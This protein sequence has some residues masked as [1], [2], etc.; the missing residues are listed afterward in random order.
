MVEILDV[1][2][3]LHAVRRS[4]VA[5][6]ES[7]AVEALEV[8]EGDAVEAN[9]VIARLDP[10]RLEAQ[11]QEAE[12][13]LTVSRAELTQREAEQ[14]RAVRDEEMMRGL[15]DQR[16]V[17]EREYLDSVREMKVAEARANAAKETIE[18]A[19]KRRDLLAVRRDD[20]VVRAPFAGRV[21]ALHTELGEW[22]REGDPVVTMVS[23]GEIEAWL[24]LPERHAALMRATSPEA[25]EL[26]LPGRKESIRADKLSVVPDVEGRSRRFTLIAHITDPENALTVGSSVRAL[27][28]LGRAEE[29]VVISSDAVMQGIDGNFVWLPEP[30]GD[31]PPMPKRV[32]VN[33]LFEREGEAV[34]DGETVK[35]GDEVIVEGNERLFPGTPLDPHPWAETRAP[36]AAQ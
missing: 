20:L 33:V 10:R 5:A 26:T 32:P 4:D 31:G 15:W 19:T 8:D 1:T 24:Q 25:V 29:R 34:L 3:T 17:A 36:A 23:T 27:V 13:A 28:P 6:R 9:A 22:L 14:E 11:I 12:A 16:A 30:A 21:V 7:A 35:A 18:A 2:G